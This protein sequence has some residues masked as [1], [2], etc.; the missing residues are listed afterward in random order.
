MP[1]SRRFCCHW[2]YFVGMYSLYH[3]AF[4]ANRCWEGL[5]PKIF[6]NTQ[7]REGF[8]SQTSWCFFM[9]RDNGNFEAIG[10]DT[11]TDWWD[12]FA[13]ASPSALVVHIRHIWSSKS[14]DIPRVASLAAVSRFL[15][16]TSLTR[17]GSAW[18]SVP[19]CGFGF[20]PSFCSPF[21]SIH[22]DFVAPSTICWVVDWWG[23]STNFE[24]QKKHQIYP[25]FGFSKKDF[26]PWFSDWW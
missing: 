23:E 4:C 15:S 26:F 19:R 20:G 22:P 11:S 13:F 24:P 17:S 12:R 18:I 6:C 7:V 2:F 5:Y 14:D 25:S 8:S 1:V 3:P 10:S 16:N 21:G 9:F